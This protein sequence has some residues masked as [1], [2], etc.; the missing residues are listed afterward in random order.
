MTSVLN[1]EDIEKIP[2]EKQTVVIFQNKV[3]DVT[4]FTSVHP[5]MLIILYL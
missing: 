4:K 1:D 2:K 5:G 3:F